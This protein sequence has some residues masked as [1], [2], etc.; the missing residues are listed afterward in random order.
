M[1]TTTFQMHFCWWK[2][3]ISISS[4]SLK[5]V[6]NVPIDSIG[7]YD[8][9]ALNRRQ[10]I[11]WTNDDPI[12]WHMYASV[13]GYELHTYLHVGSRGAHAD[14]SRDSEI[15]WKFCIMRLLYQV[16]AHDTC[17]II[18]SGILRRLSK[19][20]SIHN[21][22]Q[23]WY[24]TNYPSCMIEIIGIKMTH[25]GN[26]TRPSTKYFVIDTVSGLYTFD[27]QRVNISWG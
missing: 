1:A 8:G 25:S 11:T 10:A 23:S 3:C 20:Y 19:C 5:F 2:V 22:D 14:L 27:H 7:S 13:R 24:L 18:W 12:H 26:N 15:M 21:N 17:Y 9:S 16:S 4:I 6:F